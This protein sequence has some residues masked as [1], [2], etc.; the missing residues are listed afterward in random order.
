MKNAK[1]LF[2][3]SFLAMLLFA[4]A[5]PLASIMSVSAE[6]AG[7]SASVQSSENWTYVQNDVITILFPAGGKKPMFLWWYK[8]E[9]SNINVVKFKGLIEYITYEKPY[10]LWRDQAEAWRI[11]ERINAH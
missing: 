11:K 1:K 5:T 8:N 7:T 9:P 3:T 2:V 4:I 6:E 10:F